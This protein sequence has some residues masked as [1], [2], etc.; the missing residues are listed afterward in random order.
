MPS[1]KVKKKE[2]PKMKTDQESNVQQC[3]LPIHPHIHPLLFP[4]LNKNNYQVLLMAKYMAKEINK[5]VKARVMRK[6]K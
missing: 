1:R 4:Y 2:W 3:P 6:V 5:L